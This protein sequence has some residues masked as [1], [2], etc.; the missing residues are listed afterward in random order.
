MWLKI[1]SGSMLHVVLQMETRERESRE[2]ERER[3]KEREIERDGAFLH[4]S[5]KQI[6]E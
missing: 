4:W 2:R 6:Y 1:L 3:D 5:R